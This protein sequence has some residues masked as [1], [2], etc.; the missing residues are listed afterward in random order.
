MNPKE[1]ATAKGDDAR[2][3]RR[4]E[5]N[6]R[7]VRRIQGDLT[8]LGHYDGEL[9]GWAGELTV[10]AWRRAA[11]AAGIDEVD[12]P[13]GLGIDRSLRV[14]ADGYITGAF[15]KTAIVVHHTAGAAA[16]STVHWWNTDRKRIGTAYVIERDGRIHEVF[17]PDAYAYHVGPTPL[18]SEADRLALERESI[19]IELASEGPLVGDR[20]APRA[21]GRPYTGEVHEEAWRGH[22]LW[23]AYTDE[24]VAALIDL[25]RHLLVIH[26][27]I[28]RTGP[29]SLPENPDPSMARL[30]AYEG[31]VCGHAHLR[32]DKTDPHPGIDWRGVLEA[33]FAP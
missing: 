14:K 24:Q 7:F 32:P 30:I 33:A 2:S 11:L 20:E 1:A 12:S 29:L 13:G 21:F 3:T 15:E 4:A 25:I 10:E 5:A 27:H 16:A 17:P 19:G 22:A 18:L 28:P 9:D 8:R 26:P 31:G 23:A 6:E